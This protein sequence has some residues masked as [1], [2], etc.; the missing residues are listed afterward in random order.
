[1]ARDQEKLKAKRKRYMDRHRDSYNSRRRSRREFLRKSKKYKEIENGWG[2]KHQ[3]KASVSLSDNYVLT[4]CSRQTGL[5]FTE[6]KEKYPEFIESY[7]QQIKLKRLIK[8]KKNEK[9]KTN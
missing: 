8:Q 9:S 2:R 3:K 7:R 4:Y 6:I 5:S 1:M